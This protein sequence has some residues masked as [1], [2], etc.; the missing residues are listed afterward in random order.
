MGAWFVLR[1]GS[2]GKFDLGGKHFYVTLRFPLETDGTG[3]N[4]ESGFV[5]CA[6]RWE[7]NGIHGAT[8]IVFFLEGVHPPF[9]SSF[10]LSKSFLIFKI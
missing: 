4:A 3:T 6:N 7:Y 10:E 2:F 5:D 9:E 8:D 1:F